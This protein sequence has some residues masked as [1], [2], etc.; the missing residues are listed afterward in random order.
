MPAAHAPLRNYK[1]QVLSTN[2][3]IN[4]LGPLDIDMQHGWPSL[5]PAFRPC[6]NLG[7]V[8]IAFQ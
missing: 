7:I 8:H 4:Y 6:T 3:Q 1:L 5:D 2:Y